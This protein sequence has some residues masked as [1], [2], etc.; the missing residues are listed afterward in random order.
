MPRKL[1]PYEVGSVQTKDGYVKMMLNREDKTFFVE[2]LGERVEAATADECRRKALDAWERLAQLEWKKIIDISIPGG[3]G[4]GDTIYFRYKVHEVAQSA[5]GVWF[6]RH[7]DQGFRDEEPKERRDRYHGG[8]ETDE[9]RGHYVIPWTPALE[10]ACEEIDLRL[11]KLKDNIKD[12]L[13]R[14]DVVEVLEA[15]V[16][17]LLPAPKDE[18]GKGGR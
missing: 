18:Q 11:G 16:G 2:V 15:A 13:G 7:M 17:R 9:R 12:L 4:E 6:E 10:M 5:N 8:V 14:A 1:K 3:W